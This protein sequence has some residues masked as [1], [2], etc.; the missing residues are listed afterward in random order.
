MAAHLSGNSYTHDHATLIL[1]GPLFVVRAPS[2]THARSCRAVCRR[3][4]SGERQSVFFSAVTLFVDSSAALVHLLLCPSCVLS[5]QR[6]PPLVGLKSDASFC[7]LPLAA[8][9]SAAFGAAFL[10]DASGAAILARAA[11]LAAAI[12]AAAARALCALAFSAL[13]CQPSFCQQSAQRGGARARRA[14]R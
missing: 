8:H 5:S 7:P 1:C 11:R 2:A 14:S 12:S 4:Y 10:A 3:S 6:L 9:L 13:F